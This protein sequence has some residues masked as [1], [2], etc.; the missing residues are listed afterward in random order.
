MRWMVCAAA[1]AAAMAG[2]CGADP[3]AASPGA[4]RTAIVSLGDSFISGEGGRWL[5]N[6]SERAR[7]RSGTDRA[8]HSCGAWGCAYDPSRIYGASEANDCHR[9]DVAPI[10]SAPVPVEVRINLA[11]S[12]ARL[13]NLWPASLGGE[14][15]FGEPPQIDRLAAVARRFDV[16]MVVLTAGANDVGFGALVAGCALDW[17]RS[18]EDEPEL[19]RYEAGAE[20][21]AAL[22]RAERGLRRALRGVRGTMATAGYDR[23]DYRLVTMGYASPFPPGGLFRYPEAGWDRLRLGGCPVWNADADWA[24]TDAVGALAATTRSAA[25]AVGAEFL[26]LRDALDGHQLCD[27]RARV[28][29]PEGPSPLSAEWVRRLSFAPGSARESLH[30]NAYG[31]QAIGACLGLLYAAP[32]GDYPCRATPGLFLDGMR[33]EGLR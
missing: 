11:C 9:S 29:G 14:A 18:D 28:V 25:D 22:P 13:A 1:A 20:L 19:C 3:A 32:R 10:E 31:Q 23:S 7:T 8:A 21:G 6:G 16:H 5:G 15:H 27:R 12:G 24:A 30:P 33:I 2:G 4:G 26:D 17:A